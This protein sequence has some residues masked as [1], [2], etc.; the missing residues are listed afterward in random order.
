[1]KMQEKEEIEAM[2]SYDPMGACT[3]FFIFFKSSCGTALPLCT[4]YYLILFCY[5]VRN[6]HF[7]T[8]PFAYKTVSLC[9]TVLV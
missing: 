1:M 5:Y 2:K 3:Q 4:Y 8:E 6:F 9:L 7:G